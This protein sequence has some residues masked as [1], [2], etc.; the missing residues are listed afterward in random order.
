MKS[1]QVMTYMIVFNAVM[2]LAIFLSSELLLV[3]LDG[4]IVQGANIFIDWG[5]TPSSNGLYPLTIVNPMPNFPFFAFLFTLI[6][7]AVFIIKLQRNK[8]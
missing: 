5:F 8:E 4:R 6:I 7:N 1:K 2:G 3:L